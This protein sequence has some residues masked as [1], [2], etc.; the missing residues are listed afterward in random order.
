VSG[1]PTLRRI[2]LT[3]GHIFQGETMPDQMW[4]HRLTPDIGIGGF[5]ARG[6]ATT[7]QAR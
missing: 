7:R 6:A 2:G 5:A 4:E 1:R 3:G